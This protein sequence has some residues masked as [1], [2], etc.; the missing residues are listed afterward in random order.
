[1][2]VVAV[3][4]ATFIVAFSVG[5]LR[6]PLYIFEVLPALRAYRRAQHTENPSEHLARSPVYFDDLLILPQPY[7]GSFLALIARSNLHIGLQH[8]AHIASNPFQRWAAQRALRVLLERDNIPFF[9]CISAFW[10]T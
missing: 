8:M 3:Y 7:L 1:M 5:A 4:I 10:I 6:V 2:A 9:G